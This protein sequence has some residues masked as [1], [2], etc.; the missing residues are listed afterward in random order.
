MPLLAVYAV[1][2]FHAET[3]RRA[4]VW[5]RRRGLSW[6]GR[7]AMEPR[8][9]RRR[10]L[11]LPDDVLVKVDR[12]SMAH[13]RE[14]RMPLLAT[15]LVEFAFSLPGRLKMPGYQPQ[16]LLRRLADV[17]PP[18]ITRAPKKGFN[19]PLREWMRGPS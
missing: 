16:W 19:A 2:G 10:Y 4:A 11:Y 15:P 13:S 12:A 9:L 8:R 14:V 18:E 1:F 7:L 3:Q 17:L 5:M 6:L